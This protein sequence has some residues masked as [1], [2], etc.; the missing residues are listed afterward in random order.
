MPGF[1][2]EG[3]E[4]NFLPAG[5]TINNADNGAQWMV[6]N[7]CGGFG[8]SAKSTIFDNYNYDSKGSFDDQSCQW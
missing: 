2:Q 6:S 1:I 7:D 4:N 5:W 3:F 8:G